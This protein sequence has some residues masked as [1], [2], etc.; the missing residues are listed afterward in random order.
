[1][2]VFDR[3]CLIRLGSVVAPVGIGTEG[4]EIGRLAIEAET[5]PLRFGTLV[6]RELAPGEKRPIEIRPARRFDAGAGPGRPVTG[7]VE[8]GGVGLLIDCRGRPLRLP[9]TPEMRVAKLKEWGKAV[10]GSQ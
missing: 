5:L 10:A 8:G 2:Q 4:E 1:M 6:R 7:T 3:D 9:A